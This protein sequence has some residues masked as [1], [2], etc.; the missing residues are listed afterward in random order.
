MIPIGTTLDYNGEKIKC[1]GYMFESG[2]RT[3]FFTSKNTVIMLPASVIEPIVTEKN[4]EPYI[5]A[6]SRPYQM[7]L[8]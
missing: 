3:Y 7:R 2:E 4:Y 5:E 6:L 1:A 8:R